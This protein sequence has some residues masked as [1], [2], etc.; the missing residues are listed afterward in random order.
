MTTEYNVIS[1]AQ[2]SGLHPFPAVGTGP[3]EDVAVPDTFFLN[4]NLL[5]GGGYRSI[6][7]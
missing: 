2:P 6:A 4:A 1:A 5:A 7:A 3:E